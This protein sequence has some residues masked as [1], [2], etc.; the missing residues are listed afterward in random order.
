MAM[1]RNVLVS[2]GALT[3]AL[4][5]AGSANAL[6]YVANSS[7]SGGLLTGTTTLEVTT[8]G[9]NEFQFDI[10]HATDTWTGATG[11]KA[12]TF[13][14]NILGTAGTLSAT[15]TF[16]ATATGTFVDGGLSNGG[17]GGCD[18][19]GAF[20]CFNWAPVPVASEMLF[21]IKTTGTFSFSSTN[22]PDLKIDFTDAAG[23]KVGTL[24]SADIPF[25]ANGCPV[26]NPTGG[27]GIP[28]PATWSMMIV[29]V[30][31]IGAVMRKRRKMALAIA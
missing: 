13:N 23:N 7:N 12:F 19:T 27:G 18:G 10:T 25:C 14:N 17:S 24:F 31:M 1:K 21:D 29:G 26:I 3:A 28:E 4:L 2:V 16:P 5:M 30:G 11:L 9:N 22:V 20:F 6:S 15:E 8:V